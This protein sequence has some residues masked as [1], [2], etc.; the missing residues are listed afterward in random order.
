LT[1]LSGDDLLKQNVTR[2]N[3]LQYANSG[4]Q[5]DRLSRRRPSAAGRDSG[6]LGGRCRGISRSAWFELERLDLPAG[7]FT[8]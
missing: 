1:V 5:A 7:V 6:A 3:N 4:R 8:L 2:I